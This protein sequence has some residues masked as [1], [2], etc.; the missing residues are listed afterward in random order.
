LSRMA[1]LNVI[2][3]RTAAKLLKVSR[4]RVYELCE[5][6]QLA[7]IVADGTVLVYRDSVLARVERRR[8]QV[9]S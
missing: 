8:S 9:A 5:K 3:V 7:S 2:P 4:Q 1:V 6:G